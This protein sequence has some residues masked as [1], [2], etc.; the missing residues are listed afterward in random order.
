MSAIPEDFLHRTAK[1][2]EA[3]TQPF[4]Q[5]KKIYIEGSRPDIRVPMREIS[6]SD[7]HTTE[8]PEPN[9]PITVYDTSGPFGDPALD[10]DLMK[11]MP[12]VRSGWIAEREDT[13][14]L[15]GPTSEYGQVRQD[16]P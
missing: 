1:L 8:Q 13:E 14:Q 6:L 10:V 5:S 2:S 3:V 16:D 9:L 11:G 12:D 4:P 15:E 7:T